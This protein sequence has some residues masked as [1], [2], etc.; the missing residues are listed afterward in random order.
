MRIRVGSNYFF[1]CYENFKSKDIDEIEI[2]PEDADVDFNFLRYTH[3]T[4][5]CLFEIKKSDKYK[6][7]V[8]GNARNNLH[9]ASFF[10]PEFCKE[11]GYTLKDLSDVS[12]RLSQLSPNHQY[13][14]AIYNAYIENGSFTLTDEQR[15]A[16]YKIY[17]DARGKEFSNIRK[18]S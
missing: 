13:Y 14:R 16:A 4:A 18:K 3:S 2:I 17:C 15:D 12:V 7:W 6:D 9:I 10:I 5:H 8:L 1:S 11:M